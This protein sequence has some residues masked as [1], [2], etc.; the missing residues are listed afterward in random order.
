MPE[1][2]T[3]LIYDHMPD[4]YLYKARLTQSSQRH[5]IHDGDTVRLDV[6]LGQNVV[7]TNEA[8]R[9]YGIDAPEI[10]LT[11]YTDGVDSREVLR[12]WL[13]PLVLP[14][15]L[16]RTHKDRTGKF[17][18][19]LCTILIPRSRW[20]QPRATPESVNDAMDAECPEWVNVNKL[21]VLEGYAEDYGGIT[22]HVEVN[23]PNPIT[24]GGER[25]T[26]GSQ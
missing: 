8:Y 7:K 4:L 6:D 17:G 2:L 12:M 10:K 13:D 5:P 11:T 23:P 20:P 18:R 24:S 25:P 19:W 9:L 3:D 16:V 26:P 1:H 15:F 14:S 21:L 22:H